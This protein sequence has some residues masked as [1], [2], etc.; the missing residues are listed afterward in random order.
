MAGDSTPDR[1][2]VSGLEHYARRA[3]EPLP[4][5][6]CRQAL[7]LGEI[8]NAGYQV[9]LGLV[10]SA[11][12][13]TIWRVQGRSRG[14]GAQWICGEGIR[15][16]GNHYAPRSQKS[17]PPT[18]TTIVY[19]TEYMRWF[20]RGD[21]VSRNLENVLTY[22]QSRCQRSGIQE[23]ESPSPERHFGGS[24]GGHGRAGNGWSGENIQRT[25]RVMKPC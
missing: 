14:R 1:V 19:L 15:G 16:G 23:E 9:D 3:G 5:Q 13:F 25:D 6:V 20:Q 17:A 8:K 18:E 21:R 4:N 24:T 10:Q 2:N 7:L 11:A 12:C 22:S